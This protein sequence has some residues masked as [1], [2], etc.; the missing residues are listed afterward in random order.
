MSTP[1]FLEAKTV[2]A[3]TEFPGSVQDYVLLIA[4]YISVAGNEGIIGL[5]FGS[6]TPSTDGRDKPWFKTS[7]SGAPIGLFS[8]NGTTWA[9]TP[10]TV[11]SGTTA[12]RPASPNVGTQYFDTDVA[13]S[14][15]FERGKWRTLHGSPGDV[16]FVAKTTLA[17]ALTQNPGWS[18]FADG[19][20][21]VLGGAGS[22]PGLTER[23]YNDKVGEETVIL[24]TD[25]L[26]AHA[27]AMEWK[28]YSGQHQNGSQGVGVYPVVTGTGNTNTQTVGTGKAHTNMQPTLF[29]WCL[30]KE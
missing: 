1:L 8:W 23:L 24:A 17:L 15:I 30:I 14:L 4:Q 10:L 12:Q 27:H 3:G 16:K 9:Q 20:G 2:P 28:A 18:E 7:G 29:L 11:L 13:C 22:G 19:R 6:A 5:N 21:R 26:P 25:E